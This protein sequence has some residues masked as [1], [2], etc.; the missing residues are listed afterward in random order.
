MTTTTT[1]TDNFFID[2]KEVDEKIY[3]TTEN[4]T[5]YICD[6]SLS[7][8]NR[9]L[10]LDMYS[11][12]FGANNT[13]DMLNT[14]GTM[15]EM[16]GTIILKRYL[17]AITQC[18][19]LSPLLKSICA[20]SLWS[21]DNNDETAYVAI[22]TVYKIFDNTVGTPYKIEFIKMLSGSKVLNNNALSYFL[23]IVN[24]V[25]L[26]SVYR[27]KI[28]LNINI[29]QFI[30]RGCLEFIKNINN[31]IRFRILAGQNLIVNFDFPE[32]DVVENILLDFAL[33]DRL[34]YNTRAD[35][36]DILLQCGSDKN[37]QKAEEIILKLGVGEK[38]RVNIYENAQNVH[39]KDIEKSVSEIIEHLNS[40]DTLKYNGE[41]ISVS[42]VRDEILKNLDKNDLKVERII[43]SLN[44]I[45]M[46]SALYSIY[47]FS[48]AHILIKIW[49]F[50]CGHKD[51]NEL[52]KRL[53]EE[54]YEMAGT[55]S[56]GFASRLVNVI[57]GFSD[58]SIKISW[59]DQLISNFT[60]RINAQI[61]EIKDDEQKVKIIEE[62]CEE[63]LDYESRKNYFSFIR[64]RLPSL[65]DELWREFNN[66]ISD[67]DFDL[68]FRKALV[69]YEIGEKDV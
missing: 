24:D 18:N 50:I 15:Y 4:L 45:E 37:K 30:E 51:Y 11:K 8:N 42:Y 46:D 59:E 38:K 64:D 40:F 57:S 68:Y 29:K 28:I 54:L 1:I 58:F 10:A 69:L 26:E 48:L 62:M 21:Y 34:E 3:L 6:L 63:K 12:T 47:N 27:Y 36:T 60:G 31:D 22:D 5:S 43:V 32:K 55:C 56:S 39:T 44:R 49:T 13:L 61:R 2:E 19:F 17:I 67:C 25:K 7:L 33:S 53:I 23:E 41:E 14:I 52:Q 65:R 9:L 35:A 66:H 20:K 16:S